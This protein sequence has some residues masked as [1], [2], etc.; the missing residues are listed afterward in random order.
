MTNWKKLIYSGSDAFVN[1]ISASSMHLA[2]IGDVSASIA[3]ATAG[4]IWQTDTN[5]VSLINGESNVG[6]GD[7]SQAVTN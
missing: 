6:I 2:G 3:I 5:G 4:T 7:V 1:D